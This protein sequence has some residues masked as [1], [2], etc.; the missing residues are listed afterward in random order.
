MS[1]YHDTD[2]NVAYLAS[3]IP[4][5]PRLTARAW[6]RCEGQQVNNPTNPLNIRYYGTGG[7]IGRNSAG[8]GVY[9]SAAAGLLHA[10]SLIMHL[11]YY[12]GVR[13]VLPTHNALTIARAIEDSP[14]AGGH[15]GGGGV[16]DGCIANYVK[17]HPAPAPVPVDNYK[18]KA[19]LTDVRIRSSASK[20]GGILQSVNAGFDAHVV[21]IVT[22][23]SYVHD[24][25]TYSSWVKITAENGR[26]V[27]TRYSAAAFWQKK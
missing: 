22:G 2:A 3:V 26:T 18:V 5:M 16:R 14:W 23:G 12:A 10:A 6:M 21:G 20:S 24:G 13:R 17:S 15:Y 11:S 19:G 4:G 1:F 25:K 8:F 9:R 7:Q 27:S